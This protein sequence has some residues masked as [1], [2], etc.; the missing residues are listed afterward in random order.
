MQRCPITPSNAQQKTG[1]LPRGLRQCPG[2]VLK[3]FGRWRL[4]GVAG[5]VAESGVLLHKP[6]GDPSHPGIIGPS[7]GMQPKV[8]SLNSFFV[9]AG[10][11]LLDRMGC[12][13]IAVAATVRQHS[14]SDILARGLTGYAGRS[15]KNRVPNA[16]IL[17]MV[18]GEF[19]LRGSV[20]RQRSVA[21][22]TQRSFA[23]ISRFVQPVAGSPNSR[24]S[25]NG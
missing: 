25:E 22:C 24:R 6:F 23:E 1:A 7:V 16:E 17:S 20:R 21:K 18:P 2:C 5:K 9:P 19:Q 12:R 15:S 11:D 10:T 14:I 13:C 3:T 8:V 4:N